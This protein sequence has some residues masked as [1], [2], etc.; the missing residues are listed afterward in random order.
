MVV[1]DR[2]FGDEFYSEQR[3][4]RLDDGT[5]TVSNTKIVQKQ[6]TGWSLTIQHAVQKAV[7]KNV[8]VTIKDTPMTALVVDDGVGQATVEDFVI[9]TPDGTRQKRKS[10]GMVGQHSRTCFSMASK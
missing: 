2:S 6:P 4:I 9:H 10:F 3:P 1:T 5:C 7:V 8:E